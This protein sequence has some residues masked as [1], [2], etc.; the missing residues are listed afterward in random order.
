MTKE[1]QAPIRILIVED[2]FITLETLKTVLTKMKYEISGDAM[3]ANEAIAVLEKGET[4]FAILDI[5]IK[6]DKDGIWLAK[7]IREKYQIPFIFLTAFADDSTVKR[8]I[9]TEPYGYLVKPFDK[10]DVF[11][12]IEVAL[13]NFAKQGSDVTNQEK[14][15]IVSKDSIFIRD[16]YMF[17]KI[18]IEDILF[19]KSD[20]NY[21]EVHVPDKIH[22]VRAKMNDFVKSLSDN[23][24][25]VHRSYVIN[26][27]AV[28]R[29]GP[30]FIFINDIEIPVGANYRDEL[31]GHFNLF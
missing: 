3:N 17:V 22:L 28:E 21:L 13:K 7:Q 1:N 27:E 20:K 10:V 8:A 15:H 11:T 2:E 29:F 25:Q 18:K 9:E 24:T 12:A 5:N 23:F 16:G 19:I 4:D 14:T 26:T 30:G 6:G 31:K